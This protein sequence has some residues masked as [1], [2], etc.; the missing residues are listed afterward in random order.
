LKSSCRQK[1]EME[2]KPNPVHTTTTVQVTSNNVSRLQMQLFDVNGKLIRTKEQALMQG[3]N[4]VNL[5][6]TNLPAGVYTLRAK[7][8]DQL[9]SVRI[10]KQ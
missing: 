7:W 8:G 6:L 2:V 1:E 4:L 10:N 3:A 5:D 9:K